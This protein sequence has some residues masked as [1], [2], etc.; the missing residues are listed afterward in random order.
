MTRRS[1]LLVAGLALLAAAVGAALVWRS[2]ETAE[3]D[4][5]RL[6]Q[7]AALYAEHC[8]SCHGADLEGEPDWRQRNA[9]GLLPAPPHD[10]T[11][12]TWHHPDD[13]LFAMTKYGTAALVGGDYRSAM[14]GFGDVLSDDEIRAILAYIKSRWPAEIR[15]RQAEIDA[16]A[17]GAE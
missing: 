12:H 13:Q 4:S 7:G 16:R 5:A 17:R 11:G 6:A 10:A 9:E 8:A 3:A 15:R 14:I 1:V 2:E